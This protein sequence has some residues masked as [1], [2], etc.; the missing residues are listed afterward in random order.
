M[1]AVF[2]LWLL[3]LLGNEVIHD[4]PLKRSSIMRAYA[5]T[6]SLVGANV[7]TH[8]QWRTHARTPTRASI[9]RGRS[10]SGAHTQAHTCR[11]A[12]TRVLVVHATAPPG[13]AAPAGAAD[14]CNLRLC[15][16]EALSSV[17]TAKCEALPACLAVR[18]SDV[19]CATCARIVAPS[20]SIAVKFL[21]LSSPG[22]RSHQ[23]VAARAPGLLFRHPV[24][25]RGAASIVAGLLHLVVGCPIAM[26][27]TRPP[28]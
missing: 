4:F 7:L 19:V 5:R 16:R 24:S 28:D 8:T 21:R 17:A 27:P 10:G 6:P 22:V 18:C 25:E 14:L 11:H 13:K 2:W 9:V 26:Q 23:V 20:A 15:A 12:A 3:P 1:L